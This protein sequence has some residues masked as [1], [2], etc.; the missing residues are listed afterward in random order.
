MDFAQ[1]LTDDLE[2]V[3]LDPTEF[4]S[5]IAWN[6]EPVPALVNSL[7]GEDEHEPGVFVREMQVML[8]ALTG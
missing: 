3:I 6:G 8:P 1:M 5:E 2:Q 7:A 4:G